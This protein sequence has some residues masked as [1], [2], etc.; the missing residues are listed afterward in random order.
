LLWPR[1]LASIVWSRDLA[2][3]ISDRDNAETLNMRQMVMVGFLQAQN[4]T[5]IPA[6]WRHPDSATDF[7]SPEYFARI[8]RTLEEGKFQ[9][10]FFDDRLGMPEYGGGQYQDAI[11]NGI[12][13]VKMDPIA[14]MMPMAMATTRLGLGSTYST[15]YYEPFHVARMF[16]TLDLMTKGRAAWNVVTSLNSTEARNMGREDVEE[17]DA[18]YDQADEF[19]EVVHGHWDTWADDALI[20]DKKTGRFADPAKVKRL[21]FKGE[22]FSSR[23]PF[24]VPRSNQGHPVVIQAGQ[25]GRGRHFAAQWGELIFSH[26][27]S[28]E[29]GK[30]L[31][32]DLKADT[33]K[34]GRDPESVK[35]CHLFY[36]ICAATK[37]E[38]EDKRALIDTLPKA[39]DALML[40]SEALNFDFG[41]KPL[42]E[43]F[44]DA[45]LK[46]ME[47][48]QTIRDRVIEKSMA[49]GR[50][51]TV[52]EFAQISGRG[53][54]ANPLVGG[55]KEVADVLEQWFVEK[56]CDGFVIGTACTPGGFEDFVKHVVPELQKRGLYHKD[57]TGAT[58]RENCGLERPPVGAW[59][60]WRK[61]AAAE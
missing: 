22:H 55:P 25:S 38:A 47:G 53:T 33:G 48:L 30:K 51:P 16:A 37:S 5:T 42:D 32:A 56:A 40:L 14:C 52:R 11:A 6:S 60:G 17:H 23:G 1:S 39:E 29:G 28:L 19:M 3:N 10:G 24:T 9:L 61:L 58:L 46:G 31:L 7:T 27:P 44:T 57:Y 43:Q 50:N 21:D 12:R 49:L 41:A 18:R 34:T 2:G 59:R 36:P 54:L 13:C 26:Y 8:A 20:V 15:T 35:S 45:E 4:C